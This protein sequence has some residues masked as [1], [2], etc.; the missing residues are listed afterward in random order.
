MMQDPVM[1]ELSPDL[2]D[3][4]ATLNKINN[5]CEKIKIHNRV[6]IYTINTL[7]MIHNK[8]HKHNLELF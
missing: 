2:M 4:I 8:E 6:M 7:N 1:P 3:L 5:L